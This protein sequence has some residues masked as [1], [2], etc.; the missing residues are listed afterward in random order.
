M[1]TDRM[2][3]VPNKPK[4]PLHSFRVS[5]EA[6]KAAQAH[7]AELG[8]NFSEELRKFVVAYAKKK[9]KRGKP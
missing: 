7:A 3:N 6:W 8:E 9:P 4:T 1:T 5:D 2:G